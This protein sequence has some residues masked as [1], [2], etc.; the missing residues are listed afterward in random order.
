MT[1][2]TLQNL[3]DASAAVSLQAHLGV[4]AWTSPLGI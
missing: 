2:L 1:F 3:P 4:A